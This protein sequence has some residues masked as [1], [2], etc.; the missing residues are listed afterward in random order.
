MTTDKQPLWQR[1]LWGKGKTGPRQNPKTKSVS[2][3]IAGGAFLLVIGVLLLASGSSSEDGS[4]VVVVGLIIA[5]VGSVFLLMGVIGGG[6]SA[7][8]ADTNTPSIDS[9]RQNTNLA[10]TL[11][12]LARLHTA[13]S[14]T[15]EE[16][17]AAKHRAIN[18][19]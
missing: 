7:G 9:G 13:G 4:A 8:L 11:T 10:A 5:V 12:D 2:S 17:A 6:V 16:Y 3:N 15:D 18:E 1:I 14:L 19:V